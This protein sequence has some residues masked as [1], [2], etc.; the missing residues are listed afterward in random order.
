MLDPYGTGNSLVAQAGHRPEGSHVSKDDPP[1]G[2]TVC[3]PAQY[4]VQHLSNYIWPDGSNMND[5]ISSFNLLSNFN[6]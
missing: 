4:A 3:L 6:C 2:Q 1:S 5:S